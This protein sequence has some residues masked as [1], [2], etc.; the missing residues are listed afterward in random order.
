M[1]TKMITACERYFQALNNIDRRAFVD[2]FTDDA[3]VMDPYGARKMEGVEGL[4][5]WFNGMESTWDEFSIE[6]GEY[7][8]SGDRCAVEWKAEGK[9]KSGQ[10][11]QFKGIDVFTVSEDGL[12]S[13]LE[14][15]WDAAAMMS[16][17]S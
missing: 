16:Q 17:I 3:L 15:Y 8:V 11:A 12:V 6:T 10:I 7:F 5:R 13:K 1:T 9:S 14:A 4:S 2:C